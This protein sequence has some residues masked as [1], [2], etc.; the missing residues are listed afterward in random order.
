MIPEKVLATKT[1]APRQPE[2]LIKWL[3]LPEFENWWE[4]RSKIEQEFPSFYLGDKVDL[5]GG[6]VRDPKFGRQYS[7]KKGRGGG[8]QSD[9]SHQETTK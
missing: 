6:I 8:P 7:R 1:N 9:P 4:L 5:Q 3:D 2:V